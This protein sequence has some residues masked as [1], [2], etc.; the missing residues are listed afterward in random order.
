TRLP[1]PFRSSVS[2]ERTAA[3]PGYRRFERTVRTGSGPAHWAAVSAAVLEWGVKTRSGFT[4]EPAPGGGSR[5][6]QGGRWWLRAAVGPVTVREPV[7]VV[8][9]VERP[10]RAGF[11]YG[12]LA[13]HPV[14]GEEAFIVSRTPD[15]DLL[16]TL[17]SL[18][19]PGHGLWR[20][21]FPAL[22]VAQRAYRRRY[23]R[24]LTGLG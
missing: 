6:R 4:V 5:V 16:L 11:A 24:A 9:V 14:S 22:L 21:A 20:P 17:R 13:G 15:D 18:T 1:G 12:T 3:A 2:P 10:D 8:A 19:A 7:E 23:E